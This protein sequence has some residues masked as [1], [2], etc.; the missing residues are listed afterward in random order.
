[1]NRKQFGGKL[2]KHWLEQYQPSPHW[3]NGVFENLEKTE[4]AMQWRKLPGV[5]CRQIKGHKNGYPKSPLKIES[6]DMDAFMRPSREVKF[7]WYG[8]SAILI[9]WQGQT[10][11]IDPMLGG[12]ASPI[13][14]KKTK[15]FSENTLQIIDELPDIDLMLLSHDHYDHLDYDSIQKLKSKTKKYFVALGVKRH[16]ISWGI[17]ADYI[18][19]FDWWQGQP[20]ENLQITFT[21]TRHF[22]GRGL[23]S[24]SKCLWG[25]WALQSA[26]E[27]IW[28]SGDSGYGDH[29]KEIGKK[30]GPF[31]LGF[32]ECGQYNNDWPQ[33][34]M[35]PEESVRAAIDAGV[36]KAMPVHWAGFN[37]S[38][39]HGWKEP[40]QGFVDHAAKQSL[41]VLTPHLGELFN[42]SA[43]TDLWWIAPTI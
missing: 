24:L 14:P 23:S 32:M 28:F 15:R 18:T 21:P 25:G 1:M 43:K 11:F 27:K 7:I 37:L 6:F 31:D 35:F 20:F 2:T 34:H 8:H 3:K 29:F 22:S 9:R 40:A 38:Y 41:E 42:L 39:Q 17:E 12:D 16:L 13:A 33:I 19:E 10:I 4:T 5:I 36:K 26:E 30:L